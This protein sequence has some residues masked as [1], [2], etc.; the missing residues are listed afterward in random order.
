MSR[1]GKKPIPVPKEVRVE[2]QGRLVKIT[3]PKGN[4]SWEHP[5]GVSIEHDPA[6]ALIRVNRACDEKRHRAMHGLTRALVNNMVIGVSQGYE[7]RLEIYGTGYSCK[8]QGKQLHLNVGHMGRAVNAPAQYLIDI[9][10]GLT[11]EVEVPAARGDS[12]PAKFVVRGCDKQQVGEF[13]SEVR[14]L[15][16]PEP[17]QG[18]GI[19]YAGE[20]VRRKQG[21]AFASGG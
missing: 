3:G 19:R 11:V 9:P 4:L 12:E 20:Y 14:A 18:K 10:D 17:Y 21:K 15:R 1:V 6:T 5:E 16:K 8:V 13:A 7:R 2:V